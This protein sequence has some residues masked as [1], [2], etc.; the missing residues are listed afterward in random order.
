MRPLGPSDD[1]YDSLPRFWDQTG[2]LH[3]Q[4]ATGEWVPDPY[5]ALG[6]MPPLSAGFRDLSPLRTKMPAWNPALCT[7]CGTCL[8]GCPDAAIGQREFTP[9]HLLD[10]GVRLSA[11]EALSPILGKLARQMTRLSQSTAAAVPA[12]AGELLQQALAQVQEQSPLPAERAAAIGAAATAWTDALGELPLAVTAAFFPQPEQAR[13]GEGALLSL[14]INPHA[15]KSCGLCVANC[16]TGALLDVSQ[17][18]A[19]V[20]RS[21]RLW[22]HLQGFPAHSP[23]AA[24]SEANPLAA[25]LLAQRPASAMVGSDGTEPGSGARL[26][27]RLVLAAAESALGPAHARWR[28]DVR[29]VREGIARLIHTALADALPA[30]DLDALAQGL[31]TVD[32][33]QAEL[34]SLIGSAEARIGN[35]IDT[36]QL[37]RLVAVAQGLGDLYERLGQGRQG[38]GRASLGVVLTSGLAQGWSGAFPYNPYS[39]P[40]TVDLTG[41]GAALAAGLLEGQLRQAVAGFALV[42]KARLELENPKE[43]PRR[44]AE[45]EQLS[46]RELTPEERA[47]CPA[48]LLVGGAEVLAGRGLAQL[49]QLLGTDL[50]IRVLVLADLDLGLMPRAGMD[51]AVAPVA[52]SGIKLGLLALAQRQALVAQSSIAAPGHLL[53]SCQAAFGFEGPALLHLYAPSPARHGFPTGQTLARAGLATASRLFPLFRYDPSAD[54]VFGSRLNLTGN[55]APRGT[56]SPDATGTA[57]LSPAHWALGEQRFADYFALQPEADDPAALDLATYLALDTEGRAGK[58]PVITVA[59]VDDAPRRYRVAEPMIQI[60]DQQR[61][62]W[63]T[64]QE[65]AGLVTPFT[66]R[67]QTEAEAAVAAERQ[68]ELSAQQAHYENLMEQLRAELLAELRHDVRERL[69]SLAGY[70]QPPGYRVN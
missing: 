62:A 7:G 61:D 56:W 31:A 46:W 48:L 34:S 67:V 39:Q 9:R 44:W 17:D 55:P 18:A 47:A 37:R 30:D 68:A 21:Q 42:R 6:L 13:P 26:A 23:A 10:S 29:T 50:P 24:P 58:I 28:E 69:M 59:G 49:F 4:C 66:A 36:A 41:D 14:A 20:Q 1:G 8:S 51:S 45:L 63:R 12:S 15:C 3:H 57:T 2:V 33:R 52:D 27:L 16:P 60:C 38:L 54:G 65:L 70:S 53:D 32:T 19:I 5:L 40:V 25:V 64:L 11:A 43:A 35:T 22:A